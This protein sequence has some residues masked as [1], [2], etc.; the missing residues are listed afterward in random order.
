M[1]FRTE[2]LCQITTTTTERQMLADIISK[3]K[4]CEIDMKHASS[5]ALPVH[6]KQQ[7]ITKT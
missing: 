4:G 5:P 1:N 7:T 2:G 3:K 6:N